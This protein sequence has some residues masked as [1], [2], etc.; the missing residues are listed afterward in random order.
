MKKYL[1]P[2]AG[3]FFKANLHCHTNVSDGILSPSEV[4]SLYRSL[5]YS[6]VAFTDHNIMVPHDELND[7]SFL[8]LH[9][10]E[11]DITESGKDW[12]HS[13]CCH[14]CL[15]PLKKDNLNHSCWN[16]D[17]VWGNARNYIT[18]EM[19]DELNTGYQRVYSHEGI[20]DLIRRAKEDGY[21]VIYNHP[22]WSKEYYPDYIG[23][24]GMHA[25]EIMN[26]LSNKDGY[27][28]YN[29]RVYDDYLSLGRRLYCIGAD[30]NHNRHPAGD[31]HDESGTAFTVIK[32][33][34]LEYETIMKALLDGAFYAS[35]GPEIH[36]LFIEDGQV[37]IR[38]S[39]VIS[40]G[41]DF[42]ARANWAVHAYPGDEITTASFRI[43]PKKG[44]FRITLRDSSGRHA[45]TN[46]YFPEEVQ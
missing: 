20:N 5:G 39:P 13:K 41:I 23:Y 9:G 30:D 22:S 3:C 6:V 24:Q 25:F 31:P 12:I 46:A 4:K 34:S 18:N 26:G 28:D 33:E 10:Y 11:I 27:E 1:L 40:I 19:K 14:I 42:E 44:W 43:E 38:T 36:E 45:C 37:H 17:Y 15:I 7:E 16:P 35:E 2:E 21:F 29:P 32:A 8:A